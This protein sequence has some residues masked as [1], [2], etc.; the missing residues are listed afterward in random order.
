MA[1]T[2]GDARRR[3]PLASTD[4]CI[5]DSSRYD[6]RPHPGSKRRDENNDLDWRLNPGR[7]KLSNVLGGSRLDMRESPRRLINQGLSSTSGLQAER[8]PITAIAAPSLN[9]SAGAIML[10]SHV[11]SASSRIARP[12]FG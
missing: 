7:T 6:V 11:C 1:H 5:S 8:V 3:P 12:S 9:W 2:L 4:N 10:P